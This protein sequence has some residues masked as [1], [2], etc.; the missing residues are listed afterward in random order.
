MDRRRPTLHDVA[1]RAGLSKSTAARA[2]SGK[3]PV[4]AEARER[5]LAA[6]RTLGYEPNHL[7]VS[8]R[9]GRSRLVGLV[10]PDIANPFWAEVAK[11]AQDRAVE[12]ELSL[13]CFS[14]D[15]RTD[16]EA[17]HLRA[18]V[19]ARVDGAIVNPVADDGAALGAVGLP[20]V[21]IGSSA[22]AFPDLPGL[23]SDIPQ[24]VRLGLDHLARKGHGAPALIVGPPSR[25]ARA[26]FVEAVERRLRARGIDPAVP[27]GTGD[28]TVEGGHAAMLRLLARPCVPPFA[29]FA[30]NDLMAL[31]AMTAVR[32]RGLD[33]PGDVSVL[34][35]DGIAAG[36]FSSPGLTTVEKPARA[37]GARAVAMLARAIEGLAP[38]GPVRLPSRLVERGSVADLTARA[39]R[40]AGVGRG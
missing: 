32:E 40:P 15:W 29:V 14:S 3:G 28:Y 26:R 16:Q 13:L 21:L 4:A 19:R 25:I 35:F 30:A 2:L 9:S 20:L 8:M 34:G 36:A 22:E 17:R 6:A 39:R 18:L 7:A 1:T 33:C 5:A 24:A 27:V 12:E 31:G 37:L 11:G 38:D 10:I 23:G